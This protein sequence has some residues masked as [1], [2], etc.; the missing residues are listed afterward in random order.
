MDRVVWNGEAEPNTHL[1]EAVSQTSERVLRAPLDGVVK[2][3]A[4]TGDLPE[5]G[6]PI[7]EVSG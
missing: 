4:G 6:Q 1:P 5:Q 2:A 3:Y 7:V